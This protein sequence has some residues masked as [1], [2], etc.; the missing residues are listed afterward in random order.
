MSKDLTFRVEV[1]FS[2]KVYTDDE[3]NEVANK[4]A[5]ALK[6]EVEENELAPENSDIVTEHI[7]VTENYSNESIVISF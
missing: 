7:R 6:R 1:S 3:I 2:G 4:I 5:N